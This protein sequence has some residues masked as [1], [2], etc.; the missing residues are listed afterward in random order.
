MTKSSH[1]TFSTRVTVITSNNKH[2][3]VKTLALMQWPYSSAVEIQQFGGLASNWSGLQGPTKPFSAFC[4]GISRL[5]C[6]YPLWQIQ[7]TPQRNMHH[8]TMDRIRHLLKV[9]CC[10]LLDIGVLLHKPHQPPTMCSF[11]MLYYMQWNIPNIRP[12]F[13]VFSHQQNLNQSRSH[14]QTSQTLW[15]TSPILL[16]NARHSQAPLE[17]SKVLWNSARACWGAAAST[18]S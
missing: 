14:M 17:L 10:Q 6:P 5:N 18:C 15:L 1:N 13:C 4:V 11:M 3:I 16:S 8:P 9:I 12:P 2:F 7:T